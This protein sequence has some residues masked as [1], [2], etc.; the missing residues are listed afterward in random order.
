MNKPSPF[1]NKSTPR[2]RGYELDMRAGYISHSS[3]SPPTQLESIV[4][5]IG[6]SQQSGGCNVHSKP[7]TITC[8][9]PVSSDLA[10]H[11]FATKNNTHFLF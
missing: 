8:T 7:L 10:M 4:R 5:A 6:R 1:K 2:K 11:L 9:T 3:N